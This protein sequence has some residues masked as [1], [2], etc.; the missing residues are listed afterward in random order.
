MLTQGARGPALLHLTGWKET[1]KGPVAASDDNWARPEGRHGGLQRARYRVL[2]VSG[3][4]RPARTPPARR[5]RAAH[6]DTRRSCRPRTPCNPWADGRCA[7]GLPEDSWGPCAPRDAP[8]PHAERPAPGQ[9]L[10]WALLWPG[11]AGT[12]HSSPL[13]SPR[14][15]PGHFQALQ[16]QS[17]RVAPKAAVPKDPGQSQHV[18]SRAWSSG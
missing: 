14:P 1:D 12:L 7:R 6:G 11:Q 10:P 16:P 5:L 2:P 4:G 17:P 8:R 13:S 18:P 9:S 15:T 3:R